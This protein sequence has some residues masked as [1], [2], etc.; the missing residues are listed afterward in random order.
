VVPFYSLRMRA[1]ASAVRA[2]LTAAVFT[3]LAAALLAG[4]A[5]ASPADPE[6]KGGA[7]DVAVVGSDH[8]EPDGTTDSGGDE[9]DDE[10]DDG[11]AGEPAPAPV[12]PEPAP[13]PEAP[14]EPGTGNV[15]DTGATDKPGDK[16]DPGK[17]DKPEKD[18]DSGKQ[19]KPDK[20]DDDE[21]DEDDDDG[22]GQLPDQGGSANPG[23]GTGTQ[24]DS[25]TVPQAVT[26]PVTPAVPAPRAEPRSRN[27][28]RAQ[29]RA[30]RR[31]AD[32]P[33]ANPGGGGGD[34]GQAVGSADGGGVADAADSGSAGGP[35]AAE[36]RREAAAAAEA[37]EAAE[38]RRA[39]R[40]EARRRR[41]AAEEGSPVTR[42]V[43]RTVSDIVEVV[44][45]SMKAALAALAALAVLLGGGYFF[46]TARARRL[47]RQRKELLNEVGLLQGA[48]LPAVPAAVGGLRTSVAYR[49]AEGVGAGGD[50]YDVVPLTGGRVGF[51]LGD[52]SGHGR[53]ALERT[54]FMRY[55]LRAYLEA[56]LE[57][58]VALQVADRVIDENL[59]DDFATVLLAVHDPENGSLT[60]AS[61]GHPAPIITGP[62]EHEPVTAASSPPIGVGV[63]TGLRQTTVPLEPGAVAC[64]YTDGLSEARTDDGIMGRWRL[65]KLVSELGRDADAEKLLDS[66]A[67]ESRLLS[68][69]MATVLIT[70]TAGVTAG[71]F[72]TEQLEVSEDE[73]DGGLARRFL[74]ACDV[75]EAEAED[76][77]RQARA[78]A[79]Q[80]GGAVLHVVLGNRHRVEVLPRNVESIEA[81]SRRA[82]AR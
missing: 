9:G 24:K 32:R 63:R 60:Y 58:R 1:R 7:T 80:F 50:F 15:P 55:T 42:T 45:D 52:V 71:G 5:I 74:E 66:V 23:D 40:E 4:A 10:G 36:A 68:D 78:V 82:A 29:R 13:Q 22:S 6:G 72:R 18:D 77:E 26:L 73:L 81:A 46:S 3:L 51:I 2:A 20:D 67:R 38:Q 48:L 39:R 28:P 59:G 61:A 69:D 27:R 11:E 34:A 64:F 37:A 57:P 62:E 8:D 79:S 17:Q 35:A 43:T 47:A 21:D 30:D 41:E 25:A 70:P 49:P 56:G 14:D 65:G 53:S 16:D 19:D 31:A 75:T 33:V 54:A 12:E 76:A 44:P